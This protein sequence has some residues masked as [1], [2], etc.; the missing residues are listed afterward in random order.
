M[1]AQVTPSAL[2]GSCH[3]RVRDGAVATPDRNVLEG[4]TRAAVAEICAEHGVQLE[5]AGED[6]RQAD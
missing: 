1:I 4:R 2:V 5:I 6:V 3:A